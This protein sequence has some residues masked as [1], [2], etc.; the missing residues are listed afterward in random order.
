MKKKKKDDIEKTKGKR[1]LHDFL[2]K[3][4]FLLDFHIFRK[5]EKVKGL[6]QFGK[7][8]MTYVICMFILSHFSPSYQ[9][10]SAGTVSNAFHPMVL[11]TEQALPCWKN[12]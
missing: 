2:I 1:R 11:K 7:M 4:G 6:H 9:S 5:R 12:C 8:D 10:F 3:N